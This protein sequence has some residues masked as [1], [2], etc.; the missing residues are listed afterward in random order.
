ME[1]FAAQCKLCKVP[2][3]GLRGWTFRVFFRVAPFRKNPNICNR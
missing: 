3:V 1:R 2:F